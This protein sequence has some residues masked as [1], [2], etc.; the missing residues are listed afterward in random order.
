MLTGIDPR[1][2]PELLYALALMGHGDEIVIADANF[3]AAS[4]AAHCVMSEPL[5]LPGL[6][7]TEAIRLITALMPIDAFVEHGALRMEIDDAPDQVNQAHQ[8]VWAVLDEVKPADAGLGSIERQDFYTRA[9][10]AFAVVQTTEARAYGCFI[11]R[12]GVIF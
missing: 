4:T 1:L 10:T 12:K 5:C 7:A 11:L 2:T 8:E 3:P 6:N 9:K